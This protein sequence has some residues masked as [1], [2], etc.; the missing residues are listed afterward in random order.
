M[1]H[2]TLRCFENPFVPTAL[3]FLVAWI[4]RQINPH[5]YRG[6]VFPQ[7]FMYF[8]KVA[9]IPFDLPKILSTVLLLK[10]LLVCIMDNPIS[11]VILL[12]S[13]VTILLSPLIQYVADTRNP[14][15]DHRIHPSRLEVIWPRVV[16]RPIKLPSI[17]SLGLFNLLIFW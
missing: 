4:H 1:L 13:F 17:V 11:L 7:L 12:A 3:Q 5:K 2:N 8:T 10:F 16:S 9:E 15:S 6:F 14:Q